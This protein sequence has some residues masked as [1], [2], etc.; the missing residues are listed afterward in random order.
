MKNFFSFVTCL[1]LV[2]AATVGSAQTTF[3]DEAFGNSA[4][5]GWT[6]TTQST[7]GGF[8]F[9]T[10]TAL[11]SQFWT[12]PNTNPSPLAATNDD[13]C[14]CD[15]SN[16]WLVTPALDFS[17]ASTVN[18]GFDVFH[19]NATYQ[20][21]TETGD[22]WAMVS[23][24]S[25]YMDTMTVDSSYMDTM[26]VD[27]SYMDTIHVD[28]MYTVIDTAL[29]DTTIVDT[30]YVD[31]ITVDTSWVDSITIDASYID[32]F[33]VTVTMVDTSL[34]MNVAGAA[35]WQQI[36]VDI[37]QYAG[38]SNVKIGFHYN[39]G[40][41]WTY[42]MALDNVKVTEPADYDMAGLSVDEPSDYV[43][44]SQGAVDVS[45]TFR[46]L[47]GVAITSMDLNYSIN[48]GATVTESLSGLNIAPLAE[49]SATHG[50]QWTPSATGVYTVTM[51]ASNLNGNADAVTT[52]DEAFKFVT[53]V[54]QT[55]DRRPLLEDFGS[56]T[57]APCASLAV[58]F[59]P[60]LNT[61]GV[62][63]ESGAVTAIKYQMNWP[64]PG[65]D[66]YYNPDG[67]TRQGVYGVN[68]IPHTRGNGT[69]ANWD[70]QAGIDALSNMIGLIEM[71][72]S[73]DVVGDQLQT[74]IEVTPLFDFPQNMTLHIA[75]VEDYYT[76]TGT[77]TQTDYYS[78]ERKML[79]NGNGTV[80]NG[81]T[82]G[83]TET[84]TET[85]TMTLGTPAQG[86]Y[87]ISTDYNNLSVVAFVQDMSTLEV[88]QSTVADMP[89]SVN[90]LAPSTTEVR[91]V[92]NPFTSQAA[93][94]IDLE[95]AKDVQMTVYNMLGAVVYSKDFGKLS[96]GTSNLPFDGSSLDAGLYL[97]NVTV[98]DEVITKK[99]TLN[100]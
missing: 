92:P 17:A 4:P 6:Q 88:W 8:N 71:D 64:A 39:D 1:I 37:S 3:L 45:G 96:A 60:L 93:V 29:M 16:D 90:G 22:V 42:G 32:T 74:T 81:L 99:V 18:L 97:F 67:V 55:T 46:N 89:L 40:G 80:F 94:R 5:T 26:T 50:T 68:A 31:S 85:Y 33:S 20:G 76:F 14:N 87:N 77:T 95:E 79:P 61:N 30:F 62:N 49:Y 41:G 34:I 98:G 63:T 72:A 44:L 51:W 75:I 15:K 73:Y 82:T 78:V 59:D 47:G 10:A 27:S 7:D 83:Q 2:G 21:S 84:V 11:S 56:S 43:I 24:D 52:N 100:K 19:F 36:L 9:G 69:D 48:G 57:C 35:D 12:I 25:S 28:T 86:N 54:D 66:P 58:T 38:E 65:N 91:V 70:S 13:D 53:V 23:T